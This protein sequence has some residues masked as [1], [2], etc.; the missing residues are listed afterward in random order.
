MYL[1]RGTPVGLR[2]CL[3]FFFTLCLSYECCTNE[4]WLIDW[5]QTMRSL[6][7]KETPRDVAAGGS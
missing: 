6:R 5:M 7:D 1:A 4:T 2:V 3:G